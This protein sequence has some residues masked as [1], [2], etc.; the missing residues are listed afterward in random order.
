MCFKVNEK[1]KRPDA[2]RAWKV[3]EVAPEGRLASPYYANMKPYRDWRLGK[4]YAVR[5]SKRRPATI[6]VGKAWE[7]K[8][9][10]YVYTTRKGALDEQSALCRPAVIVECRVAPRDWLVSARSASFPVATYRALTPVKIVAASR[11][12]KRGVMAHQEVLRLKA[13]AAAARKRARSRT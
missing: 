11:Y 12:F 5:I 8:H 13:R 7:A 4:R 1:A 6:K 3:L 10:L 9:G 2:R